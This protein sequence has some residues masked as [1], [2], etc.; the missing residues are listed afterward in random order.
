MSCGQYTES[1]VGRI[2]VV[3]SSTRPTGANRYVGQ[4]I[5]ET[6]TNRELLYDGTG[7]V[8]MYE[9]PQT[10]AVAT[11]GITG[12]SIA[13]T[14]STYQRSGGTCR[15]EG[16]LSWGA[17]PS[18]VTNPVITLPFAVAFLAGNQLSFAMYDNAGT[19]YEGMHAGAVAASSSVALYAADGSVAR[20]ANT[21]I[22][23]SSPFSVG[24]G[25]VWELTGGFRMNSIYS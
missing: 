22:T 25:D 21:A 18:G 5:Y 11:T 8:I 19:S 15:I 13:T 14:G 3:T 4:R 23:T 1:A 6:D 20:V 7:W 9:P 10:W 16:R 2:S 17:T 24:S 12:G